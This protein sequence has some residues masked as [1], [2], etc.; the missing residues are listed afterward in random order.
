MTSQDIYD[1]LLPLF[2]A[3]HSNAAP[4]EVVVQPIQVSNNNEEQPNFDVDL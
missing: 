2:G 4:H 1:I 3:A